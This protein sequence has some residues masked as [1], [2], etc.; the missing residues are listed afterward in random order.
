[1]L[2]LEFLGWAEGNGDSPCKA[3]TYDVEKVRG[4]CSL[5]NIPIDLLLCSDSPSLPLH[6]RSFQLE[7]QRLAGS[8]RN[9]A[10]LG[11]DYKHADL[12]SEVQSHC[13]EVTG[14][15]WLIC[16][17]VYKNQYKLKTK[18]KPCTIA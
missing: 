18:L 14:A 3:N 11:T 17:Q 12:T 10:S 1:M 9:S 7:S 2:N 8:G 15:K 4:E 16:L 6:G 5:L 13:W